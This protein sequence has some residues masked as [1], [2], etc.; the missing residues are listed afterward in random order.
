MKT[1]A[2]HRRAHISALLLLTASCHSAP[3]ALPEV[4]LAMPVKSTAL[5]ACDGTQVAVLSDSYFKTFDLTGAALTVAE[6]IGDSYTTESLHGTGGVWAVGVV[7][8]RHYTREVWA[9]SEDGFVTVRYT[10]RWPG[11]VRWNAAGRQEFRLSPFITNYNTNV[12]AWPATPAVEVQAD[13]SVVALGAGRT[14]RIDAAQPSWTDDDEPLPSMEVLS[15]LRG[16]N[17]HV[18]FSGDGAGNY[19]SLGEGPLV[20]SGNG[21]TLVGSRMAWGIGGQLMAA[22]PL[23]AAAHASVEWRALA[24]PLSQHECR[25]LPVVGAQHRPH[26][27][28]FRPR[29]AADCHGERIASRLAAARRAGLTSALAFPFSAR[30]RLLAAGCGGSSCRAAGRAA[31]R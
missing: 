11:V 29:V 26:R 20:S 15:H 17:A 21:G 19:A 23:R 25:G 30:P 6:N 31:P 22:A 7:R 1:P 16:I 4:P 27:Q 24:G 9:G 2:R 14:W 28:C 8:T 13:G 12:T 3:L 5:M 10:E 18:N